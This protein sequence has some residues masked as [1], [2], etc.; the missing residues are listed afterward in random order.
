MVSS[1]VQAAEYVMA[2]A[3]PA[4]FR[5]LVSGLDPGEGSLL[6]DG[7]LLSVHAGDEYFALRAS[8]P[9]GPLFHTRYSAAWDRAVEAFT[10]AASLRHA[11]GLAP[12][13]S[14]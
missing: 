4:D 2:D 10:A 6:S 5:D 9:P 8:P 13:E 11:S 14:S 3:G 1:S 7:S 12:A